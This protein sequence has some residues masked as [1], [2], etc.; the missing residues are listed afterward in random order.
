MLHW[1]ESGFSGS[2][3]SFKCRSVRIGSYRFNPVDCVLFSPEGLMI[4]APVLNSQETS[5][6]EWI[7]LNLPVKLL[8]QVETHFDQDLLVIFLFCTPSLCRRV[9]AELNL[10]ENS[11]KFWD[12]LSMD[13]SQRLLTLFPC[14]LDDS[15]KNALK[16]T[17]SCPII[18]IFRPI[19]TFEAHKT[20]LLSSPNKD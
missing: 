8:L 11:G 3:F 12:C 16:E 1:K 17:F 2:F 18:N 9:S 13:K 10:R 15:V 4:R 5:K 6:S 20:L 7:N 19:T 14:C